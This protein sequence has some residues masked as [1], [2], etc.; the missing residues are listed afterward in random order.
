[1]NVPRQTIQLAGVRA[2]DPRAR[3]HR[4]YAGD[5]LRGE[6]HAMTV[7]SVGRAGGCEWFS[8]GSRV[9]YARCQECMWGQ[10]PGGW[11]GWADKDD[12]EYAITTGQKDPIGQKCGCVCAD[13]PV[14]EQEPD[15]PEADESLEMEPC[16]LCGADG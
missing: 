5:R 14:L 8:D 15:E 16:P 3:A 4:L 9:Q 6:P 13:G 1:A 10:C 12:I 11:H 2:D 7:E